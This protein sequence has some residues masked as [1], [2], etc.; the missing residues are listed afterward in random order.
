MS[1]CQTQQALSP[2]RGTSHRI[3]ISDHAVDASSVTGDEERCAISA[4]LQAS[5]SQASSPATV[6]PI[7][8][9]SGRYRMP[10]MTMQT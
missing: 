5:L 3:G 7:D 6:V 4:M 9:Q 1:T 8:E 10:G 2:Q